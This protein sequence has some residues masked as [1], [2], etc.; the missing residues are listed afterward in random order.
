MRYH[1]NVPLVA[2]RLDAA[3]DQRTIVTIPSGTVLISSGEQDE[4]GLVHVIYRQ[5]RLAVFQSDLNERATI[6]PITMT[7]K[8]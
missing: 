1:A 3:A 6:L 5:E 7:S 4:A 2:V 8:S